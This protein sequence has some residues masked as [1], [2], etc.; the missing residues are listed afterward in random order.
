[1]ADE[2][3]I[4]SYCCYDET[5]AAKALD[6]IFLKLQQDHKTWDARTWSTES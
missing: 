3:E 1:M 2:K 6:D 4:G 5:R